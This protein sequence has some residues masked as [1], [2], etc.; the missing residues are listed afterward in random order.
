MSLVSIDAQGQIACGGGRVQLASRSEVDRANVDF[1]ARR[2]AVGRVDSASASRG[3]EI[4]GRFVQATSGESYQVGD[5]AAVVDWSA[6]DSNE[7]ILEIRPMASRYVPGASEVYLRST[8]QAADV[9]RG[10]MR[11]GEVDVDFSDLLAFLGP[12]LA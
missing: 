3:V 6:K 11:A 12:L 9:S 7:Q 1:G 8:V 5:Y 2:L 4:L 10:Q